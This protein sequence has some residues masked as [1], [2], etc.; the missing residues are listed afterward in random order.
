[1]RSCVS[2]RHVPIPIPS[3]SLNNLLLALSKQ[4][5]V[6]LLSLDERLLEA[7]GIW[8]CDVSM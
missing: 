7:V 1:M 4:R 2:F 5:L 3:V 8:D 6:L